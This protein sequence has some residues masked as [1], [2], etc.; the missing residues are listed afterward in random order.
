M[1]LKDQ[2]QSD[3]KDA[4]RAGERE[5]LSVIRMLLAAVKQREIDERID[6]S[7]AQIL[8]T[9]EKQIKQRRDAAEQYAAGG[10]PELQQ[11]ELAEAEVLA[12]Y[13][14]E[15][16]DAAGLSAL[17]ESAIQATAAESIRDMGKVMAHLKEQ[18]QGRIDMAAASNQVKAR[19]G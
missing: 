11:K 18:A 3:M 4:L 2:I 16:L 12:G 7:D 9:V 17:I 5:R 8:A 14:P 6:L 15:P 13:L 19:L 1:S 10:R